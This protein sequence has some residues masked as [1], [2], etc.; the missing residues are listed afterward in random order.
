MLQA[1]QAHSEQAVKRFIR[2]PEL[3]ATLAQRPE[4]YVLLLMESAIEKISLA[5]H[6]CYQQQSVEQGFF[7]GRAT[8]VVD[9]LRERLDFSHGQQA[10][11]EFDKLYAHVDQCLQTAVTTGNVAPLDEALRWLEQVHDIW[12]DVLKMITADDA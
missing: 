8:A 10:A 2:D 3:Q 12:Q 4:Y 1:E 7:I 5:R 6:H 11:Q 9:A